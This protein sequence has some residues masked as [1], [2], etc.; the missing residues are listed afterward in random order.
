MNKIIIFL[1]LTSA[2]SFANESHIVR[3]NCTTTVTSLESQDVNDNDGEGL[4][5][6]QN[7]IFQENEFYPLKSNQSDEDSILF[8]LS[9]QKIKVTLS[10]FNEYLLITINNDG[11]ITQTKQHKTRSASASLMTVLNNKLEIDINCHN[12]D[13]GQS[14]MK[15]NINEEDRNLFK[16]T[17]PVETHNNVNASR[18]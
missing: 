1:L 12:F 16:P 2:Y 10:S 3:W 17:S 18:E 9:S 14:Y 11:L 5:G 8:V 15:V 13:Y 6:P 7:I 4:F